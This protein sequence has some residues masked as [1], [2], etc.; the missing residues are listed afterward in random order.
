MHRFKNILCVLKPHESTSAVVR[1]ASELA[2]LH[3]T[4]LTLAYFSQDEVP[5]DTSAGHIS[6]DDQGH[7]RAKQNS[8]QQRLPDRKGAIEKVV[9][10]QLHGD[11]STAIIKQVR[12]GNCDLLIKSVEVS[13]NGSAP[14]D[15]LDKLL[16]RHCPCAVW[17]FRPGR[18]DKSE[19][20]LAAMES[21]LSSANSDLNT[22]VLDFSMSLATNDRT[23][24]HLVSSWLVRGEEAMRSRLG[25]LA[26]RRLVASMRRANMRWLR[27]LTKPYT[28]GGPKF[29]MHLSKGKF[30]HAIL[31][32]ARKRQHDLIVIGANARR[33]IAELV[34]GTPAERV[35]LEADCSVLAVKPKRVVSAVQS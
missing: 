14:L 2:N 29:H 15:A 28:E 33:G 20:I 8:G 25:T 7:S 11:L 27:R 24:L 21:D 13:Q 5:A 9:S 1:R 35:L 32:E 19:R 6:T 4:Q 22:L 18:S 16:L 30:D 3:G 17:F 26:I 31:D 12:D 23:E 34:F 10:K